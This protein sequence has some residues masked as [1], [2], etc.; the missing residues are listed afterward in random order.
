MSEHIS[1]R[2]VLIRDLEAQENALK[3]ANQAYA[4]DKRKLHEAERA[5]ARSY[6]NRAKIVRN[7]DRLK[8]ALA[9]IEGDDKNPIVAEMNRQDMQ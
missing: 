1:L 7:V 3:G 2:D 6:E 9:I 5:A 4:E 8:T